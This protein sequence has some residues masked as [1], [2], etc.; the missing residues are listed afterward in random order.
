[1][2]ASLRCACG[3]LLGSISHLTR[4]LN[5]RF[6]CYCLDCQSCAHYLKQADRMLDAIGGT[7]VVPVHPARI[8][9]TQ[10]AEQLA[11]VRLSSDGMLRWY[12]NCCRMPI[13][14][15]QAMA[16]LPFAGVHSTLFDFSAGPSA[17]EE[18]LGPVY[19]WANAK[20]ARG[21]PPAGAASGTPPKM[22]FSAVRLLLRG[23]IGGLHQ[24]SPFFDPKTKRP[25]VDPLVL[26]DD[27]YEGLIAR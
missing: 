13:A 7:E 26:P 3:K 27:Q 11:C 9:I 10:G 24:P 14:N 2:K 6:V 19:A 4:T 1:M 12:T 16:R 22:L 21:T 18:V 15:T 20:D 8:T 25:R 5:R 23:L 17:R